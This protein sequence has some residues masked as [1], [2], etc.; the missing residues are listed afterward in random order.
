MELSPF[1]LAVL[2]TYVG[3]IYTSEGKTPDYSQIYLKS[4]IIPNFAVALSNAVRYERI[5]ELITF[6][7]RH[8]LCFV[9]S[10]QLSYLLVRLLTSLPASK[11]ASCDAFEYA[12]FAS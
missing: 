1:G 7:S 4:G 6:C 11:H 9:F 5:I 3:S 12:S 10:Y 8:S 2:L